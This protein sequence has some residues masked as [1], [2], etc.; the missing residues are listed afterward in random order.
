[1]GSYN[2]P[3]DDDAVI[4]FDCRMHLKGT[5]PVTNSHSGKHPEF[6]RMTASDPDFEEN[7]QRVKHRIRLVESGE[8][9]DKSPLSTKEDTMHLVFVCKHGKHRS[10]AAA[11]TMNMRLQWKGYYSTLLSM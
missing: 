2:F 6:M 4:E 1:M 10:V 9:D 11:E 7:M 8:D 5:W 3:Y